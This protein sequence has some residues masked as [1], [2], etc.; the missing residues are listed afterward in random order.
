MPQTLWS[1]LEC[2]KEV[3]ELEERWGGCVPKMSSVFCSMLSNLLIHTNFSR[4]KRIGYFFPLLGFSLS[5]S[6]AVRADRVRASASGANEC[7]DA[8]RV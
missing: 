1:E 8:I 5:L 4:L 6:R 2:K 3:K 7:H